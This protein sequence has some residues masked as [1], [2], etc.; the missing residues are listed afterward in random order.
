MEYDCGEQ[1]PLRGKFFTVRLSKDMTYDKAMDRSLEKWEDHDRT[2]SRDDGYVLVYQ[3]GKLARK[4]PASS[5]EF[6]LRKYKVAL[7]R[8]MPVY[9]CTSV[10]EK[11]QL[12]R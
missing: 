5:E 12:A 2:V 6:T 10:I 8:P 1:K 7:E 4:I 9:S 3:Y 11:N